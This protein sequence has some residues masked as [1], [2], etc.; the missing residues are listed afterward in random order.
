MRIRFSILH[1]LLIV[2]SLL[3]VVCAQ[4]APAQMPPSPTPHLYSQGGR[5]LHSP[6][7]HLIY[8]QDDWNNINP[9]PEFQKE[10]IDQWVTKFMSSKYFAKA[11]QYFDDTSDGIH[12]G[13]L[14]DSNNSALDRKSTRLNSSHIP[15]SRMPS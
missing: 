12:A 15:L 14:A 13:Y 2:L 3:S 8:Y 10:N 5:V 6:R 4:P 7:V 9:E 11:S 1:M